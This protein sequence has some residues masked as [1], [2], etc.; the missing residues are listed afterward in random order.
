MSIIA[1]TI[2]NYKWIK[3]LNK[4]RGKI[5][6]TFE[7]WHRH[8]RTH[9]YTRADSGSFFS[10]DHRHGL[11]QTQ[12]ENICLHPVPSPVDLEASIERVTHFRDT[13]Y[14]HIRSDRKE[15]KRGRKQKA[16]KVRPTPPALCFSVWLLEADR[17]KQLLPQ[18]H[19]QSLSRP[20]G[21]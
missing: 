21:Q 13:D 9:T 11:G 10:N 2:L 4:S 20:R 8:K 6:M 15:K 19:F 3:K 12:P 18:P 16:A 1:V 17:T 7:Y 5:K 14:T